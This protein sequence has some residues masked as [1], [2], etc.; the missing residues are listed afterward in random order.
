MKFF[1]FIL[2]CAFALNLVNAD[3]KMLDDAHKRQ[4]DTQIE[5]QNLN[6]LLENDDIEALKKYG[7]KNA[8]MNIDDGIP[9]SNTLQTM[10]S[11]NS[12][13]VLKE[14]LKTDYKF[15]EIY[16]YQNDKSM[17]PIEYAKKVKANPEIIEILKQHYKK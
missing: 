14:A 6:D 15:M 7:I 13:K 12:A 17:T 2:V 10:I 16:D 3:G 1:K 4:I 11:N 8:L 9:A 5:A